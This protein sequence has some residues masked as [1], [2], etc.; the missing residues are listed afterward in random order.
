MAEIQAIPMGQITGGQTTDDGKHALIRTEQS[1]GVEAIFAIADDQLRKL[2]SLCATA[3]MDSRTIRGIPAE[4]RDI[5]TVRWWE[6]GFDPANKRAVLSLTFGERA[7]LDFAFPGRMPGD[8]L[9]TLK[10]YLE[11]STPPKPDRPVN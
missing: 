10:A 6:L 7:R 9:E 4:Q 5:F 8:I 11:P 1:P 3:H 2:V